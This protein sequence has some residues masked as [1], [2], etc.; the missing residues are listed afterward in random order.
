[1]RKI[2]VRAA[3]LEAPWQIAVTK[4]HG[5]T[6]TLLDDA[7]T[8]AKFAKES[9]NVMQVQDGVWSTRWGTRAYGESV[10]A[11]SSWLGVTEIVVDADTRKL[12]AIGAT[13]GKAYTMDDSGSW[14]E[15]TGATFNTT[16]KPWFLQINNYLYIVNGSDPMTRYDIAAGTLVR[17]TSIPAP[18]GVAA[19]RGGGLSA[20]S[21]NNY[22]KVTALNDVGET[23]GSAE[24]VISTN[25]LRYEWDPSANEYVDLSWTA[26]SGAVR[27][28]IYYGTE[29]G[30]ELLLAESTT[31]T[32][33]DDNSATVN[34]FV[35]C[36]DGDT[37]GAPKF[38]V[39]GL[40]GNRLWGTGDPDNPYRVYWS[41]VAQYLGYFSAYYGGGWIDLEEGGR[42]MPQ[43]VGHYRTGKGDSSATILCSTPE[44]T[45]SVWQIGLYAQTVGD[46]TFMSAVA[47]KIVGAIGTDSPHSVV[48]AMD[49][50]IFINK[51]GVF[52]LGNKAQVTNVLSTE[53]L[54]AN[55]RPSFRSLK[56]SKIRDY[57]AY[58][59]D[60]KIFFSATESG[61]D[62]DMIFV[63][64][65]ERRNWTWKW[66]IGV[67]QFTEHTDSDGVTHFLGVPHTGTQL[68]EF[69][70]NVTD[71]LGQPFY[72]SVIT[73]L[74]PVARDTT[75]FVRVLEAFVSLARPRGTIKFEVIGIEKR[76]GFTT[77]AS[78][79]I[80]TSTAGGR[81][82]TG[83][84]G[85]IL[86][87]DDEEPLD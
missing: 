35:P 15:V 56:L 8:G 48:Q 31:N 2:R 70:E 43:W 69:S 40:S 38:A 27:Y 1:M 26:V 84:L 12:F 28:Q 55:I 74:L 23:A 78:R 19:T 17:Y 58:W 53:E 30:G 51:R 10:S 41:G 82:W 14:T 63:F 61:D 5:G 29:T 54:S 45:G 86:L 37:T 3:Q 73:G 7:R 77:V 46:T 32:Y 81:L 11:E 6:S 66:T 25:K 80:T 33:R 24:V 72:Q 57:T 44:G 68:W 62:N 59:Y 65:T 75:A 60:A 79:E 34:P 47:N 49:S 18:T 67:R 39:L 50:V 83:S 64:D 76:K 71:D 87:K 4:F 85:E 13:T 16:K 9:I 52:T 22:Y 42:E 36:P 21:N 20:G